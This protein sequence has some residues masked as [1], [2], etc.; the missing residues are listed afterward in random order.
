MINAV[1]Q[2]KHGETAVIDL[3]SNY[4]I[5]YRELRTVGYQGSPEL[6]G[7]RDNEDEEYSVKLY[8]DSD[9]GNS[10]ILLLNEKD[11]LYDAYQLT[12]AR[13]EI[14]TDLEQNLLNKKYSAYSEVLE[15]I[16][17]MKINAAETRLTFYCSLKA[18]I[19]DGEEYGSA[20]KY[21]IL[22]NR[23]IIEDMLGIEQLPDL[24]DMAEY[25]GNHSG[26]GKK[27]MGIGGNPR[28]DIR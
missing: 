22:D 15:D 10:M 26:I 16:N 2:N 24:G 3:T 28:G 27:L 13:E 14:K 1:V 20:A 8:S 11:S 5:I 6:L 7:L 18:S 9:I 17:Q 23:D 19:D 21:I 4:H 12:N 25:V